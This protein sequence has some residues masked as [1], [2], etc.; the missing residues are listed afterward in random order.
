[1]NPQEEIQAKLDALKAAIR[2]HRKWTVEMG[3][4]WNHKDEWLWRLGD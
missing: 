3:I 4:K 1:M 2:E